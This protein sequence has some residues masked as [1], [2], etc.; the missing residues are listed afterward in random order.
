MALE[1]WLTFV[2]VSFALLGSPGPI[3]LLTASYALSLGRARAA[4]IIPGALL[5][6]FVAMSASLC[7]VGLIVEQFPPAL[8]AL[9]LCGAGVLIWLGY[10]AFSQGN[11]EQLATTQPSNISSKKVFWSGFALAAL[12][13]SGFVFFT[14]FVPQFVAHERPFFVQ[15]LMLTVTFLAIGGL[16]LLAWLFA[17]D[18]GRSLLGDARS[19][20]LVRRGSGVILV[21]LGVLSSAQWALKN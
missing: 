8:S 15:A 10:K 7:G 16:T 13:P 19:Q 6:D 11:S 5:G 20:V 9:K 21:G 2:A 3:T 17:A 18:K 12:H 14:S 1:T 4:V